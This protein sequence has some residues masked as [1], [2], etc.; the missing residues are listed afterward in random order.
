MMCVWLH[1]HNFN[2]PPIFNSMIVR[3]K[4]KWMFTSPWSQWILDAYITLRGAKEMKLLIH[5]NGCDLHHE[6]WPFHG[7]VST[8]SWWWIHAIV[9]R[10]PKMV[11]WITGRACRTQCIILHKSEFHPA[12]RMHSSRWKRHVVWSL[13]ETTGKFPRALSQPNHT[14]RA[15]SPNTRVLLE[16]CRCTPLPSTDYDPRQTGVRHSP[17][18]RLFLQTFVT[19]Q[20]LCVNKRMGTL[21]K[22]NFPEASPEPPRKWPPWGQRVSGFTAVT[23]N[24]LVEAVA[25]SVMICDSRM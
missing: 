14:G 19:Q 2:P 23:Y 9:S 15:R 3:L 18:T 10:V 16:A 8:C 12:N 7:G 1:N 20:T 13:E 25:F 21:P 5:Y 11:R 17:Q 24:L 22:C 6:L 4:V